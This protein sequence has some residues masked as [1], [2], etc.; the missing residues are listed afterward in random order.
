MKKK[1]NPMKLPLPNRYN[2]ICVDGALNHPGFAVITMNG[3]Q[4]D[5]ISL[6]NSNNTGK[7]K[8]HGEKLDDILKFFDETVIP[9]D[10]LPAFFVREH[11]V[12]QKF[13]NDT[14]IYEQVGILNWW[15]WKNKDKEWIEFYPVT[16]KKA[17]AGSGRA[18]KADVRASLNQYV[19]DIQYACDDE[20]DALAIGLT[21]LKFMDQI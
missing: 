7:P 5:K 10:D 11:A 13:Y 15:L 4:I 21:F 19:G 1:Q 14:S 20:S 2:I 16:I 8:T 17:I 12:G 18:S 6:Y 9:R 3:K